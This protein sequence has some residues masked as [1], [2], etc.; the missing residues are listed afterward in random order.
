MSNTLGQWPPQQGN[1]A[2]G[3]RSPVVY[4]SMGGYDYA[5]N[6]QTCTLAQTTAGSMHDF[7]RQE[8]R[9][10]AHQETSDPDQQVARIQLFPT[11]ACNMRCTYCYNSSG[12]YSGKPMRKST[13]KSAIDYRLKDEPQ[14]LFVHFIGGEPT[15]CLDVLE[16]SVSY[17][18]DMSPYSDFYIVTNGTF[19]E[20]CLA[21]LVDN[22]FDVIVSLDGL[23]RINDSC[24]PMVSGESAFLK[25][26][27]NIRQLCTETSM[28]VLVRSTLTEAALEQYP[29]FLA[30]LASVGVRRV[31]C[32]PLLT[33]AGRARDGAVRNVART[34]EFAEMFLALL[35]A[36][37]GLGIAVE[38][39][40][41]KYLQLRDN[42]FR[43]PL[44][45]LPNGDVTSSAVV[46]HPDQPEYTAF[47]YGRITPRGLDV[48]RGTR[49]TTQVR[50]R[51]NSEKYCQ[52]C[53]IASL[54]GGRLRGYEFSSPY[55]ELGESAVCVM[56]RGMFAA[57]MHFYAERYT[58]CRSEVGARVWK[59]C[60][61]GQ[62]GM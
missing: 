52:V 28:R 42:R 57:L 39:S 12:E 23:S 24:R 40:L 19:S 11:L 29:D 31:R 35:N 34:E 9:F 21:F 13:A 50:F 44:I 26:T 5:Y 32:E 60:L 45:V 8:S 22:D 30:F 53:S 61:S 49:E 14:F 7:L 59:G 37:D 47:C 6:F 43:R 3:Q 54:C 15:L 41:T 46:C 55:A 36:A 1:L 62:S 48:T 18:Q 2:L 56:Y 38:S 27:A 20:K 33:A 10:S 4:G 17:A 58:A 16:Y 51:S 25:A